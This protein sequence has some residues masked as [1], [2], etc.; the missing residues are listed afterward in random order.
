MPQHH[1]RRVAAAR[2]G[3]LQILCGLLI[4]TA[5]GHL[6]LPPGRPGPGAAVGLPVAQ[7]QAV[8]AAAT[9]SSSPT[10]RP[11]AWRTAGHALAGDRPG[12]DAPSS[13]ATL[14]GSG[15]P[16]R[17]SVE[18]G[19]A[20]HQRRTHDWRMELQVG[21]TWQYAAGAGSRALRAPDNAPIGQ[22]R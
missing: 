13:I 11:A 14:S 5:L 6:A 4:G 15:S 2:L 19:T 22:P 7:V 18:G 16:T 3:L 20:P 9:F 12:A 1:P 21:P 8:A 10:A 17:P